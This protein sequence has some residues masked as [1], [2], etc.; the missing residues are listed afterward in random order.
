MPPSLCLYLL[1][2]PQIDLE[3]KLITLERRKSLALLAYL[4]NEPGGHSR[5]S[6]SALLWPDYDPSSAFKNL[7]QVLWEI[8]KTLGEGWLIS[9]RERVALI[10]DPARVWL[11]VHQFEELFARSKTEQ[12]PEFQLPLLTESAKLYRNQF[13]HGFSLKDAYPFNDWAF[14]K[15]EEL[16]HIFSL[17][18][19][20]L[21]RSHCAVGQAS[22]AI[23][24]ARRLVALDPLNEAAHRRL[25]EVYLQAGQKNAALK[26]Y[27]T[28]EQ[29]LRKELNLDPQP[30]TRALY[31]KIRKGEVIST[32]VEK[33]AQAP[34]VPHNLPHQLTTFI[35]RE[36]E[37]R[38][39]IHLLQ[40][41]RM[42]SL[43][44]AGGIGKT[45]LSVQIARKLLR[46]FSQGVWF[47]ALDSLFDPALIASTVA[48]VFG[49]REGRDR[50]IQERLI[51]SL[52][53]KHAL[54]VLDNCE[55]LLEGCAQLIIAL[56]TNC[57]N[58][59][60]LAT[61]REAL[62]IP[63]EAVYTILSLPLPEGEHDSFEQLSEFESVQLFAERAGLALPSF[64]LTDQN[65]RAIV[66]ICRKVDGIPLAIELA[67]ARVNILQVDEILAQLEQSLALL[68]SDS[69]IILPRHQ[70]LRA[71]M[72]WS[73]ALLTEAEQ[74]FLQQL[75]VF[76]G[77]WTLESAQAV[78][79]GDVLGLS[80]ALATKSLI[81]VDRETDGRT[82][83]RFHEIVREFAHEKLAQSGNEETVRGL[84][85]KYFVRLA[86]VAEEELRGSTLISW[87]ERLND[88]RNNL[89]TALHWAYRTD[90]EAGLY[91]AGSLRRYWESANVRE[92]IQ[93]LEKF[94]DLPDSLNFPIGRA[95][96]LQTYA[97]LL[98]WF[99]RF[100]P[101]R[102][103]A[104]ESLALYRAAGDPRGEADALS[105]LA[106]IWQFLDDFEL[107]RQLL[108]ESLKIAI[109]LKDVRR[110]AE[111]YDFLG[112]DRRDIQQGF[113]YWEKAL[114]LYRQTGD[115]IALANI[116][117]V[118]GQF[119]IL[120]GEIERGEKLLDE[121]MVVW[122]AN[123]RANIW[124]NVKIA[125]S[126][127]AL[128]RGDPEEAN[129]LLQEALQAAQETGN[130]M[131]Y[132]WIRVRMGHV[133]V[134][135]GNMEEGYAIL[136]EMAESFRK[137]RY[138]IGATFALEGI[139]HFAVAS[140]DLQRA[141]RLI[142]WAEAMRRKVGE[143]RMRLEQA[144]IDQLISEC[145]TKMGEAP[146]SDAYEEGGN[147]SIE[148][149]V[150]CALQ[151][152]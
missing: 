73:W 37:Q 66:H 125:R 1:G 51:D 5:E 116:L 104:E 19:D 16:Q 74:T 109:S 144:D 12:D 86:A 70:T 126:I 152:S 127:L 13:L 29:I 49:I 61:S 82:R 150:A 130:R 134:R 103:A 94:N 53:P 35:G 143:P 63:G 33:P 20:Q 132:S 65:I 50:Q 76:A 90:I 54:L 81:V 55:H 11:D 68:A 56:L 9:D 27:Q 101:A 44:G 47:I 140:G 77:G 110:E 93:W 40:N 97:W 85:L 119:R 108:H 71:S 2:A 114:S 43:V 38:E 57:P 58:I 80:A 122:Q 124:E 115:Q 69:R 42:V 72:E 102:V 22:Q 148:E 92:G 64:R 117:S 83:F 24:W 78:F 31:Q 137:D 14:A 99:Q 88:E 41:K 17:I 121:A 139:A 67:A 60:V 151:E 128:M 141:A 129:R 138:T 18:L 75:S 89:R 87:L 120:D 52:R 6:L 123:Q 4:A 30:A 10:N 147:M 8:Q 36:R 59:K 146:F 3:T 100:R 25:M 96:A 28:C 39:I 105:C 118:L 91:L 15:S 48:S 136:A 145:V 131:S 98:T 135:T 21:S 111:V 62:G 7:R 45:S 34:V 95:R 32:P 113:L 107:A 133:A 79:E 106:N 46:D 84:H 23:P 142:G 149:A 112:W 26:Q